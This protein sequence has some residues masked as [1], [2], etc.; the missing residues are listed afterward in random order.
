MKTY[1]P[2]PYETINDAIAEVVL[3]ARSS[4]EAVS[5]C[6]NGVEL[7]ANPSSTR[8]DLE[9]VFDAVMAER[10]RRVAGT[11]RRARLT[12]ERVLLGIGSLVTP[13][14]REVAIRWIRGG[15]S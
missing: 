12:I 14:D 11:E 2:G 9:E 13:E 8:G 4:G 15:G 10:A 7:E 3:M 1:V 6:F 5:M